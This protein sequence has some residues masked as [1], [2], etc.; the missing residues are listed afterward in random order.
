MKLVQLLTPKNQTS[1]LEETSTIRQALE[2]MD[3]RKFTVIPLLD[4]SGKYVSTISEGD[5]LRYI[6]NKQNFNFQE[7]E[8]I[9]LSVIE[10]YRPYEALKND[11]EV[12]DV[13]DMSLKQNFIPL[14][15]DRGIYMG[16]VKRKDVI[17]HLYKQYMKVN[18]KEKDA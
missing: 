18:D 14:V 4:S 10:K 3:Y 17:M 6:K 15:D 9:P 13:I 2:K 7:A 8:K 11:A 5:I 12:K 16:I 1:Y